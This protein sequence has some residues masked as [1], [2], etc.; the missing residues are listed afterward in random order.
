MGAR[1]DRMKSLLREAF[2]ALNDEGHRPDDDGIGCDKCDLMKKI[3]E[4][5]GERLLDEDRS[6]PFVGKQEESDD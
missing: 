4:E 6:N 1:V 3:E 2:H 5:L